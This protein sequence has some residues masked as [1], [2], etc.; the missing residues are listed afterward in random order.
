MARLFFVDQSEHHRL[1]SRTKKAAALRRISRSSRNCLF[2]RR[3]RARACVE[4]SQ[5]HS[6]IAA[7][8]TVASYRTAS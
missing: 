4:V 8:W 2:S 1:V 5:S 6:L 7:M 3:S